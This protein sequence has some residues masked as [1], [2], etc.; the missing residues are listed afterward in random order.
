MSATIPKAVLFDLDGTLVHTAPDI[1]AA[2][3]AALVDNGLQAVEQQQV[4]SFIGR[5]PRVLAERAVAAQGRQD[6]ALVEAVL[7]GYVD[8]YALQ[9][10]TLSEPTPG[11]LDCLRELSAR[12]L[13]LAVVTNAL[14]RFVEPILARAGLLPYLRLVV[15][16]DRLPFGKPH[17]APLLFACKEFGVSPQDSLMVGDSITDIEAAHAAGC[18]VVCLA[19]GYTGERPLTP[20]DASLIDSLADLPAWIDGADERARLA[21]ARTARIAL[22]HP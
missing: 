16:G 6:P 18:Q 19:A 21:L 4:I 13:P 2:V 5:G 1:A 3:N 10:G 9:L 8:R 17:P 15:G 11:A 7:A 12:G 14:Q 22:P 20:G